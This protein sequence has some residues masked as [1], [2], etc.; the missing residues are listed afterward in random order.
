[1]QAEVLIVG[2]GPAGLTLACDLARRGVRAR[3][4]EQSHEL[5]P[6]SRGKGIQP[7]SQEVFDDLGVL[8]A[9]RADGEPYPLMTNW[10]NGER[11]DTWDMLTRSPSSPRAPYGEPLMLPQWRTQEILFTRLK[12]WGGEVEFGARLT[13]F[14]QDAE[15]V[16]AE[17]ADP[18]GNT[19]T[20]RAAYLVGTDGGRSTVRRATGIGMSGAALDP[21]S[22]LVAD[23]RVEGLSRDFWHVWPKAEGGVLVMC[24]L[25]AT[26]DFQL[27]ARFSEDAGQPDTSL[28]GVRAV[29]AARTHLSAEQVTEVH[30]SSVHRPRAAMA[31][32]FRAGRVFLAG[33]A[34]HIHPP[35]G[36]QGLNTSIQDA[37]NLGWKLGQV[38][39]HGAPDELLDTYE[40]ERIP[41]AAGVLGIS[42]RLLRTAGG[43]RGALAER[44]PE[45]QQLGI[46]YRGATLAAETR[47]ALADDALQAGDRAPQ[48][49]GTTS[50][51][52]TLSLFDAF[53]GP[54]FT[55]LAVG[56]TPPAPAP[57]W[58]RVLRLDGEEVRR[59]Y[60]EG[61][62]LIRP[63]GYVGLA[64]TDPAAVAEYL[65]R[66][67]G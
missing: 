9:M 44:G 55:L 3:V 38:L 8:E 28:D 25:T 14:G 43:E 46:G 48:A 18:E 63:D 53:R 67:Q 23:V 50:D 39:R 45:T 26:E 19:R 64:G 40:E 21:G 12:E 31:D 5:F 42:T 59:T 47:D 57:D 27:V 37:Y 60:G 16:T 56:L 33:D 29:V 52:E 58:V 2:A 66:F 10:E 51:G 49:A 7:R 15:G 54:H 22:S 32:R 20:I 4:V 62:F 6:G 11:S 36:G 61:L 65:S 17:I 13:G 35:T 1:M 41:V 24:P 30:W 34:A